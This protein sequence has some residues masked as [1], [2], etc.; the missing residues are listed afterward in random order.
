MMCVRFVALLALLGTSTFS[1]GL[2]VQTFQTN[3]GNDGTLR[4][5]G[6][7]AL[8]P[9]DFRL[10]IF[11]NFGKNPLVLRSATGTTVRPIVNQ[12][13]T[14]SLSGEIGVH[15]RIGVGT[16]VPFSVIGHTPTD[17]S[18][19]STN[20]F[21]AGDIALYGKF[22]LLQS[23]TAP[24]GL[25]ILPFFNVPSGQANH[26]TG[27]SGF[28]YG[29][30]VNAD[31]QIERFYFTT[32][33][34]F[35]GRSKT[36]NVA[37]TGVTN[38]LSVKDELLYGLGIGVDILPNRVRLLADLAGS[39]PLANFAK[40]SST[41]PLEATGALEYSF[42]KFAFTVGGGGGIIDGYSAPS[43]R[44][45]SG[46]RY[47]GGK[48]R[49]IPAREPEIIHQIIL[50]GVLFETNAYSL[51]EDSVSTLQD[52]LA[53]LR[54]YQHY[55]LVVT[56]HTDDRG[57]EEHNMRLSR[58][59]A[60]AVGAYLSEH[61]FRQQN[62]HTRGLGETAPAYPNDSE[63]NMARNRRVVIDV[64]GPTSTIEGETI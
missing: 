26:Y 41:S 15:E 28:D 54:D 2:N 60:A 24:V 56:G 34:G 14:S 10:A 35:N 62:I 13:F 32:S 40:D 31:K 63:D 6:T 4:H 42:P 18:T 8:A 7:Q 38:T 20:F 37:I 12:F 53:T 16:H 64:I 22:S 44:I 51:R 23:D 1:F 61:G 46:L 50:D 59:R 3:A 43:Y 57:S 45:F 49:D 19:T 30:R 29:V 36:Q 39:T 5:Q 21:R 58:E 47:T 9:K 52:N 48:I 27:D 11:S 33:L 25:A 55:N 17:G